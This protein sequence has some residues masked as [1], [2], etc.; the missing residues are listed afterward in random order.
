MFTGN[1]QLLQW[2]VQVEEDPDEEDYVDEHDESVDE[3]REA[4]RCRVSGSGD[5]VNIFVNPYDDKVEST[6]DNQSDTST[7]QQS[8]S[9]YHELVK[10]LEEYGTY[11]VI[12]QP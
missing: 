1:L 3:V 4:I 10:R 5:N 12:V 6:D 9:K 2:G 11:F 7:R 8:G